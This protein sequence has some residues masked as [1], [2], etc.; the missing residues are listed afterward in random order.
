MLVFCVRNEKMPA[1]FSKMHNNKTSRR[2]PVLYARR[3]GSS[4]IFI[5]LGPYC[6]V[7]SRTVP[8][9][10]FLVRKKGFTPRV[11][12]RLRT[13]ENSWTSKNESS[14]SITVFFSNFATKKRT[15]LFL[16]CIEINFSV[17]FLE[18]YLILLVTF[19]T[20]KFLSYNVCVPILETTVQEKQ[21]AFSI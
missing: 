10:L 14:Q 16:S 3:I 6:P 4:F 9:C 12:E 19:T 18:I 7:L 15:R 21:S 5:L 11:Q 2:S 17:T 1:G 8:S 20:T 13:E